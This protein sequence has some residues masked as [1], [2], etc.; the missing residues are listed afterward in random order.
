M[1]IHDSTQRPSTVYLAF[2]CS[3]YFVRLVHGRKVVSMKYTWMSFQSIQTIKR[4]ECRCCCLSIFF[5]WWNVRKMEWN[6]REMPFKSGKRVD[7]APL[8]SRKDNL[9]NDTDTINSGP[10]M[11][12][13]ILD[14]RFILVVCSWIVQ[15]Y[16]LNNWKM[17]VFF[18]FLWAS[19]WN[20]SDWKKLEA[21]NLCF[22]FKDYFFPLYKTCE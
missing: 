20:L 8:N 22:F 2:E 14:E 5:F 7:N 12:Y 3:L 16:L 13:C 6:K 15:I 10:K 9:F 17:W 18:K 1:H 4:I 21:K 11:T 19:N